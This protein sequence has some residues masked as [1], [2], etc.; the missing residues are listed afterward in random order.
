MFGRTTPDFI[1]EDPKDRDDEGF[2]AGHYPDPGTKEYAEQY[3]G[4]I[5]AFQTKHAAVLRA[6]TITV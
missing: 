1:V 2:A 5:R 3:A 4:K 6:H